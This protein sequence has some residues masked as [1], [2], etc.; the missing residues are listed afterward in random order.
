MEPHIPSQEPAER[1]L[2]CSIHIS[3]RGIDLYWQPELPAGEHKATR[4]ELMVAGAL[5]GVARALTGKGEA[6]VLAAIRR[7]TG[8]RK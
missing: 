1:E 6:D 4:V 2:E 3:K 7:G 8:R 5:M